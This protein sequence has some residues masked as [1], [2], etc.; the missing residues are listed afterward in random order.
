VVAE[1]HHQAVR[2][3]EVAGDRRDRPTR[4]QAVARGEGE[5][6]GVREGVERGGLGE[7]VDP[8]LPSRV[9]QPIGPSGSGPAHIW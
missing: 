3:L 6:E 8:G 5:R 4:R 7:G 9:G 2:A 1:A